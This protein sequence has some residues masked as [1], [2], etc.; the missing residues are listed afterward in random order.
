M[1]AGRLALVAEERG[2]LFLRR[3]QRLLQRHQGFWRLEL[4]GVNLPHLRH[5]PG[6]RRL[7]ALGRGAERAQM[8]VTDAAL[9]QAVAERGLGEARPARSGNGAHVDQQGDAGRLQLLVELGDR[10]TFIADREE[11]ARA[12]SKISSRKLFRRFL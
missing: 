8:Q 4:V 9:A 6:P 11:R 10:L 2:P 1:A 5:P 12:Q 7:A 3:L